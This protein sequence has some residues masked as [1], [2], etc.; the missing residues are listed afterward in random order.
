MLEETQVTS[1]DQLNNLTAKLSAMQLRREIKLITGSFDM[2]NTVYAQFKV[3]DTG[4]SWELRCVNDSH[5]GGY[6]KKI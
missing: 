4:Q 6:L 1:F 2:A 3:K 5:G